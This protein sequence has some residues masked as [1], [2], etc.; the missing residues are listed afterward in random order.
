MSHYPRDEI[1]DMAEDYEM[2]G[3]EDDIDDEPHGRFI[4]DSDSDGDEYI[5]GV[6]FLFSF[7]FR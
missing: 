4:G 2:A 5:H 7:C 1:D 3:V 6:R